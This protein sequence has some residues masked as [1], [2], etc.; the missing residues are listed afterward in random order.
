MRP[1][2]LLL[3]G[4]G[5]LAWSR[6]PRP[7][8]A[9]SDRV[10]LITGGSRGLGLALAQECARLGARL[11]L[12]ARD[13]QELDRARVTLT[14]TEVLT[15]PADL[16]R[17][18]EG[19]RVVQAA[20]ARFGRLDVLINNA[21]II[22]VG[23]LHHL[24]AS[25]YQQAMAIN[26]FAGVHLTYAARP[27]LR[28]TRGRILNI[29][30]IGA[31]V[32]VPHLASYVASKFAMRGFSRV[33]RAELARDG[34]TV[35]TADPGL[36]RTGSA[37]HAE[38][39]GQT[40]REYLWFALGDNAPILSLNADEAARRL[41]QAL[42]RGEPEVVVGG[43][44]LALAYA[45]RLAPNVLSGLLNV[46]NRSLPT[47]TRQPEREVGAQSETPLT[48]ANPI[49]QAAEQRWNADAR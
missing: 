14:G 34:I 45:E 15:V 39:R 33:S 40:K 31:R 37:R 32:P 49:K 38:T 11:V 13:E 2:P 9:L 36:M 29:T 16:T 4:L 42:R 17:P 12:T 10:V 47:P 28:R 41:V 24:N 5:L 30:S 46:M 6:R 3:A 44:A 27:H 8:A 1:L 18:G 20:L 21:G 48:R 25:D 23:P 7:L 22:Q 35:V 26:F 43:P 19:E